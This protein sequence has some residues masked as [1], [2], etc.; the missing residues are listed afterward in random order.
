MSAGGLHEGLIR[1][2]HLVVR[3]PVGLRRPACTSGT[4]TVVHLVRIAARAL[5]VVVV[6]LRDRKRAVTDPLTL[7]DVVVPLPDDR[8]P[9]LATPLPMGVEAVLVGMTRDAADCVVT[10]APVP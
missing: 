1:F 9:V 6:D 2:E 7:T 4:V 8:V 3:Y 5:S 10:T